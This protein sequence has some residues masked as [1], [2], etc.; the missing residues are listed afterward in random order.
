MPATLASIPEELLER[1]LQLVLASPPPKHSELVP[2][3]SWHPYPRQPP[4]SPLPPTHLAPLLVSRTWLRIATP[5][6]YRH[7]VLRT[8]RATARLAATLRADPALGVCIRSIRVEGTFPAFADVARYCPLL[9]TLE[10]TVDNGELGGSA[11]GSVSSEESD[12]EGDREADERVA[13]F[14]E[15]FGCI[16]DVR[17]LIVHKYAYLTQAR[18]T[19]VFEHLGKAIS[20]WKNLE[21]VHI[22][23]RLSPSPA[24]T[25]LTTALASAPRLHTLRTALPA[26]WNTALLVPAAN[27]ALQRIALEPPPPRAADNLFLSAARKHARLIELVRAGTP[28]MRARAVTYTAPVPVVP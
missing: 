3:P 19:L 7:I 12:S 1:V 15:S 23:F 8:P 20:T 17:H 28:G 25:H 5:I 14:C 9:E 13:Q 24:T 22:A 26:V 18:P 11:C 21:T 2:R 16:P 27:P 10:L 6:Q 4:V